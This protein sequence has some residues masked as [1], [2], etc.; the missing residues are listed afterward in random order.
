[1]MSLTSLYFLKFSTD[2][3]LVTPA[4]IGLI[5][6]LSRIWDAVTDPVVGYLSDRTRLN[7]GRRRSWMLAGAIPAGLFFYMLFSS[8]VDLPEPLLA[9]Y[10][11]VA[12]FGFFTALRTNPPDQ[13]LPGSGDRTF[14]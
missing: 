6:G 7:F 3:L 12:V 2:V 5:F 10:I 1:M 11:G 14:R 4:L 8:P 13:P 9:L